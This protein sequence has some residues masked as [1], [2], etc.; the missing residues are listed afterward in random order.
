MEPLDC[1]TCKMEERC[2][3]TKE[4]CKYPEGRIHGVESE[5]P[6]ERTVIDSLTR[7]LAVAVKTLKK[8]RDHYKC[9]INSDANDFDLSEFDE[10]ECM[11]H[12]TC[13]TIATEGLEEIERVK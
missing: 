12:R 7:Q 8:I 6:S 2:E 4:A 10:G 11:G 1:S 5:R 3:R 13:S 9:S